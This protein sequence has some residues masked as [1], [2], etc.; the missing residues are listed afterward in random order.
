MVAKT[1]KYKTKYVQSHL[2]SA[3]TLQWHSSTHV[4]AE[5]SRAALQ[6]SRDGML[7]TS[8]TSF[9]PLPFC[10]LFCW[11]PRYPGKHTRHTAQGLCTGL[12]LS[13]KLFPRRDSP[14]TSFKSLVNCPLNES[15]PYCR[16]LYWN[17][18]LHFHPSS[19]LVFFFFFHRL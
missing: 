1:I 5:V 7:L 14:L 10:S 15:F 16:I 6:G 17:L 4:K 13:L 3:Q 12:S 18:P 2:C 11:A 19:P 9:L 8:Q